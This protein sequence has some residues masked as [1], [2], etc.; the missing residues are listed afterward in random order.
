ML[1]MGVGLFLFNHASFF[2]LKYMSSLTLQCELLLQ[3]RFSSFRDSVPLWKGRIMGRWQR[4]GHRWWGRRVLKMS[5]PLHPFSMCRPSLWGPTRSVSWYCLPLEL[6][7]S[8]NWVQRETKPIVGSRREPEGREASSPGFPVTY[9]YQ[10][11]YL[12]LT[13]GTI[14]INV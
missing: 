5:A 2:P 7:V 8:R 10:N 14:C 3:H 13:E 1:G 9:R 11:K 6:I 12:S 4:E